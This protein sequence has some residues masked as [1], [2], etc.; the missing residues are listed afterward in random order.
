MPCFKDGDRLILMVLG[1]IGQASKQTN[2]KPSQS[3]S[4][5]KKEKGHNSDH[6]P[7]DDYSHRLLLPTKNRKISTPLF[8][9]LFII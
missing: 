8:S 9:T 4:D 3:V 2:Y 7:S 5:A 6:R 1:S